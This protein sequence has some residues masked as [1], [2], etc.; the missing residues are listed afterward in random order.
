MRKGLAACAKLLL[1]AV[2]ALLLGYV[3][4]LFARGDKPTRKELTSAYQNLRR[5][6]AA[7]HG[8]GTDHDAGWADD[9]ADKTGRPLLSWRVVLLPY[10]GEQKL[11]EEFRLNEPWDG[12]HNK[13][14]IEKMPGVYAPVRGRAK[15]GETVYQRFVGPG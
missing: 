2:P 5:I 10:L 13:K 1:L 9:I 4:A 14:L 15:V 8:Y 3:L 11:Y 6:G 7:F 12:E